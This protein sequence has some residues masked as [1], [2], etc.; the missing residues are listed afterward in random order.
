MDR[1]S[2]FVDGFN[3]YFSII[4]ASKKDRLG[5]NFK[6]LDL[7]EHLGRFLLMPDKEELADIYYFSAIYKWSSPH[8]IRE[9]YDPGKITR[10]VIYRKALESTG[11]KTIFGKYFKHSVSCPYY[12]KGACRL[13]KA[14]LRLLCNGCRGTFL[15]AEEKQTDVAIGVTMLKL[16]TQD[17][18]DTAILVSGD[19]DFIPVFKVIKELYP[20]KRL[21]IL[22]PYNRANRYFLKV[23]DFQRKTKLSHLADCRLPNNIQLP[24]GTFLYCPPEWM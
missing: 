18:Y 19:T 11:V 8:P 6:W 20:M 7:K 15:R 21:G 16:A 24:D 1:V 5:R 4:E 3:L 22:F 13:K 12:N 10:H 23:A 9:N 14:I 2:F 17:K